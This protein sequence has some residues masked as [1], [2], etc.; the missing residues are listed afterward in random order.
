MT[1]SEQ[2]CE[3][4]AEILGIG[5]DQVRP[6]MALNGLDSLDRVDLGQQ[7]ESKFAVVVLFEDVT[8]CKTVQDVINLV[9]EGEER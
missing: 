5:V 1:T 8:R 9:N 3:I 7:L 4:V 2:V 6:D